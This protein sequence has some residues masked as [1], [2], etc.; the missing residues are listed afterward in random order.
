MNHLELC[1]LFA[2]TYLKNNIRMYIIKINIYIYII[3][4][5]IC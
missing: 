5:R 2:N 3:N 4:L 1:K